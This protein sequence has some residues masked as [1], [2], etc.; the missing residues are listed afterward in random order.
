MNQREALAVLG[1]EPGAKE[2]EIKHAYTQ[3]ALLYH[4]DKN[5]QS[6][7]QVRLKK[8][9]K[10]KEINEANAV[11]MSNTENTMY[12]GTAEFSFSNLSEAAKKNEL[13]RDIRAFFNEKD[14]NIS[15]LE[16]FSSMTVEQISIVIENLEKLFENDCLNQEGF[17]IACAPETWLGIRTNDFV[18]PHV[19]RYI[20]ETLVSR[21]NL[22]LQLPCELK[23]YGKL[24]CAFKKLS[25]HEDSDAASRKPASSNLI[26]QKRLNYLLKNPN[27]ALPIAEAITELNKRD[28]L[29]SET[30]QF[31]LIYLKEMGATLFTRFTSRFIYGVSQS[32][33]NQTLNI[34]SQAHDR[35]NWARERER[36]VDSRIEAN[37]MRIRENK[38]L[39]FLQWL[40]NKC[41]P[42]PHQA[43]GAFKE[44]YSNW[45]NKKNLFGMVESL[46]KGGFVTGEQ[47]SSFNTSMCLGICSNQ[48]VNLCDALL[49]GFV[50][51]D[52]LITIATMKWPANVCEHVYIHA[53]LSDEGVCLIQNGL[54]SLEDVYTLQYFYKRKLSPDGELS[55][56]CILP[57]DEFNFYLKE[58][59][60]D[61]SSKATRKQVP[62]ARV[63]GDESAIKIQSLIRGY[64]AINKKQDKITL[65]NERFLNDS[66][67]E[68]S[69]EIVPQTAMPSGDNNDF[70]ICTVHQAVQP[71]INK[72]QS[73]FSPANNYVMTQEKQEEVFSEDTINSENEQIVIETTI[74]WNFCF[75]ILSSLAVVAGGAML[76]VGLLLVGTELALAG[77]CLLGLGV[78]AGGVAGY[79]ASEQGYR[80]N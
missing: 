39:F 36:S 46:L 73:L 64:L 6:T 77:A 79:A 4:P 21:N 47:L 80:P 75:K 11:L 19:S 16:V 32:D 45:C 65:E 44:E 7:E 40:E 68:I 57:P 35:L 50:T 60:I 34:L 20:F 51:I 28:L 2:E 41:L 66:T 53:L 54:L 23:D 33:K 52:G 55:P 56:G 42:F 63:M 3:L 26:T 72:Y 74:D 49:K 31:I 12:E 14:L 30:E 9:E 25:G 67:H 13:I 43:F 10:F 59:C 22:A 8:Q 24:V 27:S 71:K 1:L 29:N 58:Q 48:A 38:R 62:P 37:L 76:V 61:F 78:V 18:S 17:D 69:P 15:N 5:S 70:S